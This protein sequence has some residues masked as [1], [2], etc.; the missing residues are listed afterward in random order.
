VAEPHQLGDLSADL[1]DVL[2]T[3]IAQEPQLKQLLSQA[4]LINKSRLLEGYSANVT[5][6]ATD[7]FALLGNA[8][9]FLD[10]VFSSGVTIA[11]QSASL[12]ANALVKQLNGDNINWQTEYAEPLMS[13]VDTFRTYVQAWYDCRFQ[14]AIFYHAPDQTI[15]KMICSILAGYAWDQNNPF[16]SDSKRRLD[17]VVELCSS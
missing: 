13:G 12:A 7:K 3:M 5:T 8:G 11:M 15:K 16:V 17:M 2:L 1:D 10:P 4:T 9:E 6:L 14:Q